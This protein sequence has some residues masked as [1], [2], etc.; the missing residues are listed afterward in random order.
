M[1]RAMVQVVLCNPHIVDH[2]QT[3]TYT[4]YLLKPTKCSNRIYKFV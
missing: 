3:N 1:V 4:T 2:T